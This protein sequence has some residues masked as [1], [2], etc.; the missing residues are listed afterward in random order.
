MTGLRAASDRMFIA[1]GKPVTSTVVAYIITSL[2]L[3]TP[4]HITV[5]QSVVAYIIT[6]LKLT[7][8]QITVT[9][10]YQPIKIKD[11]A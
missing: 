1:V 9:Q 7:T 3:T 5:T 6:S 2:K 11:N 8:C 4:C 10:S